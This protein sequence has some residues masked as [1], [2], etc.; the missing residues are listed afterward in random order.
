MNLKLTNQT[1]VVTGAGRGL[2]KEIAM[3]L[4]REGAN[5]WIADIVKDTAAETA[6]EIAALGVKSGYSIIDIADPEQME[7]LFDDAMSLT[8]R[9]DIMVNVAGIV[10]A[11]FFLDGKADQ[12]KNVMNVNIL[13][14]I[15]GA[16]SALRRMM[17]NNSGKIV[18]IASV[19]G[20]YG[21]GNV[22]PFYCMTKAAVLN[23]TQ[24]IAK[25]GAPANVTCNAVCPGIIRTPMWEKI[26]D[27]R[28]EKTGKDREALW[29]EVLKERIPLGR[30]QE[31]SDI[32]NAVLFFVSEGGRN[33]TGQALNVCGGMQMN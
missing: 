11:D 16:Q 27:F 22:Q 2:G 24:S 26:L 14:V 10:M 7:K 5:V 19:A 30:A 20:R 8:G 32:A 23:L 1:A 33:I 28:H 18:N 6:K 17:P 31:A 9:V 3:T 13:G 21:G 4:A 29:Q 15:N 12:I 25:V